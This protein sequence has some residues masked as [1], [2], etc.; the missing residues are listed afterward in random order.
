[1]HVLAAGLWPFTQLMLAAVLQ[2][3]RGA[4]AAEAESWPDGAAVPP[5]TNLLQVSPS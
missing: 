2:A 5:I 3:S 4:G 1:M